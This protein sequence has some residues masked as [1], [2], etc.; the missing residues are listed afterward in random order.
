MTMTMRSEWNLEGAFPREKRLT[1]QRASGRQ[2]PE[3]RWL[4][5]REVNGMAR[6]RR[7]MA[8]CPELASH[9]F[10]RHIRS[11]IVEVHRAQ[12]HTVPREDVFRLNHDQMAMIS[13]SV[14]WSPSIGPL[15]P[16]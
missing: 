9:A 15:A 10:A 2:I 8:D 7:K 16:R 13:S 3:G 6:F 1:I 5:I 4:T 11:C 14:E 12:S